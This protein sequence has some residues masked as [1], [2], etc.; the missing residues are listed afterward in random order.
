MV[1]VLCLPQLLPP[2]DT[3]A[4][5]T[6]H[7]SCLFS[8]ASVSLVALRSAQACFLII[9]TCIP[10]STAVVSWHVDLIVHFLVISYSLK[11]QNPRHY[12]TE[13]THVSRKCQ[14]LV[15]SAACP[16]ALSPLWSLPLRTLKTS[17][18]GFFSIPREPFV[19]MT[20]I[21]DS[22][23]NCVW[24]CQCFPCFMK[25]NIIFLDVEAQANV[26]GAGKA[27]DSSTQRGLPSKG[28]AT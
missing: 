14:G 8:A 20:I 6:I 17:S 26:F 11:P 13:P 1:I 25:T 22:R 28:R 3:T 19:L 21:K 27:L 2:A 10:P 18:K 16:Q 7:T 9:N 5:A 15:M 12:C 24:L 4:K 23:L